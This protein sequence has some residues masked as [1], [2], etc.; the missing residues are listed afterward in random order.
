M[1]SNGPTSALAASWT[2]LTIALCALVLSST[3][4]ISRT[5]IV[6]AIDSIS[7]TIA[8]MMPSADLA[9]YLI[10]VPAVGPPVIVGLR[11]LLRNMMAPFRGSGRH[12][13]CE[14]LIGVYLYGVL[15]E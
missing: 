5:M 3:S 12:I 8:P 11:L 7:A 2:F 14:V 15:Y 6:S 4:T 13:C 9:L 1:L 10:L